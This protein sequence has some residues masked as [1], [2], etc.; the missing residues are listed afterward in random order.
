M[1]QSTTSAAYLRLKPL[2]NNNIGGIVEEHTRYW[3]KRKSDE[4]AKDRAFGAQEAKLKADRN[5][6]AFDTYTGMRPDEVQGF[7]TGQTMKTYEAK[8]ERYAE[9]SKAFANGDTEAG[10]WLA[11][12]KQKLINAMKLSETYHKKA[13]A[14]SLQKS[15]GTFNEWLDTDLEKQANAF[16]KGLFTMND[17]YSINQYVPST[18]EVTTLSTADMLDSDYLNSTFNKPAQFRT[19]GALIAKNLLDNNDGNKQIDEN[20]KIK[21]IQQVKSLFGQNA[22]ESLSWFRKSKSDGTFE[23]EN[24]FG[25]LSDTERNNLAELYYD[26]NVLGS[27]QQA[28]KT[29]TVRVTKPVESDDS[30]RQGLL[31]IAKDAD[32][33][34]VNTFVVTGERAVTG[35][36]SE[37]GNKITLTSTKDI[38]S[39]SK[40]DAKQ[41]NNTDR[42]NLENGK[43]VT[44]TRSEATEGGQSINF[45]GDLVNI[46]Q[47]GGVKFKDDDGNQVVVTRIGKGEDGKLVA[48]GS[49]NRVKTNA[50][51]V[52]TET[53]ENRAVIL[54]DEI[55]LNKLVSGLK[56]INNINELSNTFDQ[57]IFAEKGADNT[58]KELSDEE[59]AKFLGI[60]KE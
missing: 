25:N 17:D 60:A 46:N 26:E 38:E 24:A 19:N 33:N 59:M 18:G 54:N 36:V 27:I 10:I 9:A 58:S 41:L 5:K 29:K 32:G 51:E 12:E 13:Q 40:E 34:V 6:L 3:E 52:I 21:G 55:S 22:N 2:V 8:E 28:T 31:S 7:L 48:I 11:D 47:K 30:K 53:T 1:P 39:L 43:S 23:T 15:N 49:R 42:K 16:S 44:I 45:G 50:Q 57:I 37:A 35:G 20:T 56:G 4:E 14:L